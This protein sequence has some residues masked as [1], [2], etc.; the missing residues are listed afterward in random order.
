MVTRPESR[1]GVG[2]GVV[3]V[4]GEGDHVDEEAGQGAHQ[5]EEGGEGTPGQSGQEWK[6]KKQGWR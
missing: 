4:D 1:G 6:S 5:V 2:D 3:E